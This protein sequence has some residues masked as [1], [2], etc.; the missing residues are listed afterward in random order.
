[1][2]NKITI[3]DLFNKMFNFGKHKKRGP[4]SKNFTKDIGLKW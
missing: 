3:K 1:M 2:C 4:F